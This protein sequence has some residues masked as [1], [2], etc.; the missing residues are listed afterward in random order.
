MIPK[1]FQSGSG[2]SAEDIPWDYYL[3][4]GAAPVNRAVVIAY[5]SDGLAP[6]WSPEIIRHAK[7]LA[8]AGVAAFIPDYLRQKPA[9]AHG[10]SS[11]VFAAIPTRHADWAQVLRDAVTAAHKLSFTSVG[12]LGFSLGGFL[13]LRIRDSADVIVAYF[14]PY[15]FPTIKLPMV[16][17]VL[18]GLGPNSNSHLKVLVNHGNADQLVPFGTHA[19]PIV[20][21]LRGEGAT[22]TCTPFPAAN[23]GFHGSD[24][25]NV[26]ARTDSCNQT[27]TF[28]RTHL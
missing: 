13:S 21:D 6:Q 19:V 18:Q 15:E 10:D 4:S 25:A 12:L 8:D 24:P 17:P 1:S 26:K 28:F 9:I 7:V 11:A 23:H 20:N 3:P 16:P 5:G 2:A 22:V 27:E 14:A